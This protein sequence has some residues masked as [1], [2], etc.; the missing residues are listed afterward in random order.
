MFSWIKAV[1]GFA[2]C[3]LLLAACAGASDK[4]LVISPYTN[5]LLQL[6]LDVGAP[7]SSAFAVSEDGTQSFEAYCESGACHGQYG[8][9][10]KAIEGCERS[11]HGRCVVLASNGGVRRP[12]TVG[13]SM[14]VLKSALAAA[15]ADPDFV[16]GDR[17]RQ[18]LIGNSIV[19]TNLQGK[20][21]WAEYYDPNGTVRG[22]T[23]DG[24]LFDGAWKI[25]GNTLC[26]DYHSIAPDWCG[27]FAEAPDGSIDYYQDG[28]FR[29]SYPRSMLQKGNPQNL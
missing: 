9:G 16:S 11:G 28:T 8:I 23:D 26:V 10:Q 22:R 3:W 21:V 17:I 25:D 29:K 4:P 15:A 20:V 18:E 7:G 2:V 24:R 5:L 13:G 14:S 27:Q 19:E 6:Y 12:Y 1:G